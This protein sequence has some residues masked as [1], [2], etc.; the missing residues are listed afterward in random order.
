MSKMRTNISMTVSSVLLAVT[1]MWILTALPLTGSP[2]AGLLQSESELQEPVHVGSNVMKSRL[3]HR[4]EP[5]YPAHLID[6]R[7]LGLVI[8]SAVI[9]KKGEVQQVEVLRGDKLDPDLNLA[10]MEA[11]RQWRYEPFHVDGKPIRV[12]ATVFVRFPPDGIDPE[13]VG[14]VNEIGRQTETVLKESVRLLSEMTRLNPQ[15]ISEMQEVR[16]ELE[17]TQKEL[18][19]LMSEVREIDL[20]MLDKKK[21]IWREV[22]RVRKEIARVRSEMTDLTLESQESGTSSGTRSD[23]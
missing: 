10:A 17:R 9:G 19:H 4:V 20:Q 15:I 1:G 14:L 21:A 22:E 7:P 8:L 6:A 13:V 16:R 5:Q 23:D 18:S 2:S 3:V 12:R 11:V